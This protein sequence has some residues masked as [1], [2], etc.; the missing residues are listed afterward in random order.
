MKDFGDPEEGMALNSRSLHNV[1]NRY[2]AWNLAVFGV[3]LKGKRI[4]D[5]GCGPGSYYDAIKRHSPERYFATDYSVA[6]LHDMKAK[7]SGD[8]TCR[9][10]KIDLL[11]PGS[12]AQLNGEKFD[13][14]IC[15]DVLEHI[16]DDR[17]AL[18]NIADVVRSTGGGSLLL[19]IPAMQAVYGEN[20]RSIGHYRRYSKK[21]LG[22]L[23]EDCGFEVEVMRYQNILG[24]L[25]WWIIGSVLKR[26]LAVSSSE[27]KL[28]DAMVPFFAALEKIIP[29]P[30][31]LSLY[32]RCRVRLSRDR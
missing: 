31:G 2:L 23:L 29:P 11:D 3:H 5:L 24:L 28:F 4:L 26:G 8:S 9:F 12:L 22:R 18:V 30:I 14:I 20:D 25:P 16:E 27:G 1:I 32:A 19:R 7:A 6:F 10:A 13:Y 21:G 15:F 17:A